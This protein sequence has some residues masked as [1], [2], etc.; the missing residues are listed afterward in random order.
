MGAVGADNVLVCVCVCVCVQCVCVEESRSEK[1]WW[2]QAL[3]EEGATHSFGIGHHFIS[4][5]KWH[6]DYPG[7]KARIKKN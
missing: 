5:L 2:K 4:I 3:G 6:I 7:E 1:L